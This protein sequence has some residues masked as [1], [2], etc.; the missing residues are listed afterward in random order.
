MIVTWLSFQN[1]SRLAASFW[2]SR[3]LIFFSFSKEWRSIDL[4][5][6]LHGKRGE[7]QRRNLSWEGRRR[8]I[9]DLQYITA[10]W[11]QYILLQLIDVIYVRTRFLAKCLRISC[12]AFL[13]GMQVHGMLNLSPVPII[14]AKVSSYYHRPLNWAWTWLSDDQGLVAKFLAYCLVEGAG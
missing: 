4:M 13:H 1:K 3:F 14:F 2:V 5:K 7:E 12:D 6:T 11:K 8:R 10:L 9:N